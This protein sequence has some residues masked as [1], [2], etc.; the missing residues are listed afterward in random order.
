MTQ[1]FSIILVILI[2]FA[3]FS[4][5][6]LRIETPKKEENEVSQMALEPY[7]R[8]HE[9]LLSAERLSQFRSL[10]LGYSTDGKS[11][12]SVMSYLHGFDYIFGPNLRTSVTVELSSYRSKSGEAVELSPTFRM[13]WKPFEGGRFMLNLRLPSQRLYGT[14]LNSD[15]KTNILR[16]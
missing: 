9:S 1:K 10:S 4:E 13:D 14:G 7:S 3:S 16:R 2:A 8:G 6:T 5:D 15:Y 11:S 12:L